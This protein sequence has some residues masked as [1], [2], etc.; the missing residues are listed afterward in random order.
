M[1]QLMW[2]T[3]GF[4]AACALGVYLMPAWLLLLLGGLLLAVAGLLF[5]VTGRHPGWKRLQLA[6]LGFFLATIWNLG[7]HAAVLQPV[8]AVD[9]QTLDTEIRVTDYS[10]ETDYG[11][12]AEGVLSLEGRNYRIKFYLNDMANCLEPGDRVAGQFRLRYTGYGGTEDPTHHSADRIFL[13]GYPVGEHIYFASA[14]HQLRDLPADLRQYLLRSLEKLFPEDTVA[15]AKALLMGDTSELSYETDTHLKLSG[16][17]H[18]AAVSGLHVSILFSML[19]FLTGKRVKLSVPVGIPLLI[20]FAAMAGFSPSVT[21]ACLMQGLMLLAVVLRREYDP[22]TALAFAV[23]VMLAINPVVITSVGFQ[24]SVASVAGIFLLAG[25]I[26]SWLLDE[27]RLG[28][29]KKK[30]WYGLIIKAA[31]SVGVSLGALLLTTPL[32]A[33]YFGTVS[34]VSVLTNLLCLWMVTGIFCGMIAACMLGALWQPLGMLLAWCIAWAVRLVLWMAGRIG[35]FPLASV[36]TESVYI[37]IWLAFCYVLLAVFLLGRERRPAVLL[38]CA[39]LSLC[40]ALMASWTE[41]VLDTYRVTVLDVGQ[42]QCVLLQSGGKSYMVDCGG[43]YDKQAADKAAATLLS[44][45]VTR[46][47]GLILTHYDQDHVGGAA[48]LLARIS[49]DLLVL[50]EG[51]GAA[52]FEGSILEAAKGQVL[53]GDDNLDISWEGASIRIF[54]SFDTETSNESSLCVLFHTEKCDILITGD[55]STVGEEFLLRTAALPQLSALIIGHHGSGRSTGEALLAATRPAVAVISVGE[56][57]R[58]N[59]P[60]QAVLDRLTAYGCRIRRT[61]LEGTIILRG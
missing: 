4:G 2:F 45:G 11:L 24:L 44:Q 39:V 1:R 34:L 6:C 58:Y 41:P 59:H 19:F 35:S 28:K 33:W 51:S 49:A 47:D 31:T 40:V 56:G 42:G 60:A 52:E 25:R 43:D 53:R 22:P 20:V 10:Y 7:Y 26:T 48:Y 30:K 37:V 8:K 29:W 61:D 54:A 15:F 12:A 38:S 23:L 16:I 5:G 32:T 13:L 46:L 17:R 27:K 3:M 57:N 55:R 14:S 21:R 9:G 50:P 18:I 36:Y